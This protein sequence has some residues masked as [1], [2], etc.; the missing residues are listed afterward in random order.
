MGRADVLVHRIAVK[1][2][3]ERVYFSL[4]LPRNTH[5]IRGIEAG[6]RHGTKASGIVKPAGLLQFQ[7][8]G[9]ANHCYSTEL[10]TGG[11]GASVLEPGFPVGLP[12]FRQPVKWMKEGFIQCGTNEPDA[13]LLNGQRTLYGC[14]QNHLGL[15]YNKAV[16]YTVTLYLWL[17]FTDNA[18]AY[19]P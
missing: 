15:F 16:T 13:I 1:R 7:I 12:G 9:A 6:L 4:A 18:T 10:V 14:Y 3:E 2:P 19:D 5:S 17:Q 8:A 11:A